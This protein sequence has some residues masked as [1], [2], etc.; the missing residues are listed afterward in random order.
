MLNRLLKKKYLAPTDLLATAFLFT[1]T[2]MVFITDKEIHHIFF[3]AKQR[4]FETARFLD[5][6]LNGPPFS[7]ILDES[8]VTLMMENYTQ[9]IICKGYLL[10]VRKMRSDYEKY[11]KEV[12]S[13]KQ[14]RELRQIAK[15]FIN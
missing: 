11:I 10:N 15:A 13:R 8:I 9:S 2:D 6:D 5:F 3:N 12:L 14:K 4:N 1:R 7:E